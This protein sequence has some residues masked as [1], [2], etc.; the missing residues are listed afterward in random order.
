MRSGAKRHNKPPVNG[1]SFTSQDA[2]WMIEHQKREGMSAAY[3]RDVTAE[4][5]DPQTLVL[6]TR[7]GGGGDLG[8]TIEPHPDTRILAPCFPRTIT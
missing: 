3:W 1:R 2:A 6:R 5:P 8:P 7:W 4:T